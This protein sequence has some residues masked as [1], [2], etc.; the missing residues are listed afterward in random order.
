MVKD[1]IF[2]YGH[3][4]TLGSPCQPTMPT[5]TVQKL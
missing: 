2:L 5:T 1:Y 3:T 4:L